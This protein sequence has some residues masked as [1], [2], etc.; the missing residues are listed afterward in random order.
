MGAWSQD[1]FEGSLATLP[2]LYEREGTS[3]VLAR[4]GHWYDEVNRARELGELTEPQYEAAC[5]RLQAA[6]RALPGEHTT[7]TFTA[8]VSLEVPYT[9]TPPER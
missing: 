2:A 7:V 5:Q 9:V 3:A 6:V 1:A 4:T 8:S